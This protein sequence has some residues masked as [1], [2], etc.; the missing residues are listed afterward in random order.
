MVDP[1][2]N[3]RALRTSHGVVT[4][5]RRA[6]QNR[7][8][9]AAIGLGV[10][11]AS[12][13]LVGCAD[14]FGI[15]APGVFQPDPVVRTSTLVSDP[16]KTWESIGLSIRGKPI[17]ATT[18]GAGPK[19]LY[20]VGGIHGDEPEG[21]EVAAA[22]PAAFGEMPGLGEW[23]IRVVRDM[24]PDGS[25]AGKK[26]N[27]RGV[28]LN[29]NWPSKDFKPSPPYSKRPASELETIALKKDLERFKPDVVIVFHASH[30]GPFFHGAG[31]DPKLAVK[32]AGGARQID[33][34]W[35]TR[36]QLRYDTPGSLSTYLAE[37]QG[38]TAITVEFGR[39][40]DASTNAAAVRA[41][42]LAG[43]GKAGESDASPVNETVTQEVSGPKTNTPS[44]PVAAKSAAKTPA[45]SRDRRIVDGR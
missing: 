22:L 24:N 45:S 35:T 10:V 40:K 25:N 1:T 39:M 36:Q 38:L 11:A 27:T 15:E 9:V 4:L 37:Q 13:G 16:D 19:R 28:D 8:A 23:T 44:K 32:L 41:A 3:P 26:T 33:A 12:V 17:Q 14:D 6:P 31:K 5:P 21:P 29:R 7:T 34:N 18:I 30:L 2:S 43:L 42:L 20:I